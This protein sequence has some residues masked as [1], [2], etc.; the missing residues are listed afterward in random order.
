[1]DDYWQAIAHKDKPFLGLGTMENNIIVDLS[2]FMAH[3]NCGNALA[4]LSDYD[5]ALSNYSNALS[6]DRKEIVG[7]DQALFNRGNLYLDLGQFEQAICDYDTAIS[8]RK[9]GVIAAG[10]LFNKGNALVAMGQF[11]QALE[12]YRLAE[13]GKAQ[14]SNPFSAHQIALSQQPGLHLPGAVEGGLHWS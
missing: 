2:L 9:D 10:L 3:F 7:R 11:E 6:I 5:A 1:M 13:D 8:L 14:S 4:E 12:C